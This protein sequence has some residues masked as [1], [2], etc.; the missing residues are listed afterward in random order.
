MAITL[1][2]IHAASPNGPVTHSEIR[3]ADNQCAEILN[4]WAGTNFP[5][6]GIAPPLT[7]TAEEPTFQRVLLLQSLT[8]LPDATVEFLA[9]INWIMVDNNDEAKFKFI[10]DGVESDVL[11]IRPVNVAGTVNSNPFGAIKFSRPTSTVSVEVLAAKTVGASAFTINNCTIS[12]AVKQLGLAAIPPAGPNL[13]QWAD[14]AIA[15][16]LYTYTAT[17]T[18]VWTTN[19]TAATQQCGLIPAGGWS[20]GFR[21]NYIEITANFGAEN[22]GNSISSDIIFLFKNTAGTTVATVTIPFI[23]WATDGTASAI[24]DNTAD[25]DYALLENTNGY[26]NTGPEI[27]AITFYASPPSS[28]VVAAVP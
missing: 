5:E 4:G 13:S 17:P 12:A 19:V 20:T 8:A 21:N 9:V 22:V 2:P 3:L 10:V 15:G 6:Q 27:K 28:F 26:R 18:P 24:I 23:A 25:L 1:I 16:A 14:A 11:S 7:I